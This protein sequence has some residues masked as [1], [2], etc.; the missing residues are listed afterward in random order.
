VTLV[1]NQ[2]SVFDFD[3]AVGKVQDSVTVEAVGAQL[4]SA[5]AEL[6]GVL[7]SNQVVDLPMGRSIQNLMR[8]TPGVNAITTGQSSI[9]SVNFSMAPPAP[10]I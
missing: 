7:T 4:Q 2:R 6:G 3:L 5:T 8:I 10:T 9:P 1:V